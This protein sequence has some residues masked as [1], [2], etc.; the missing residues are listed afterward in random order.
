MKLTTLI[1]MAAMAAGSAE[2]KSD[3]ERQVKVYVQDNAGVP[4]IIL[5]DARREAGQIF[6]SIGVQLVWKQ[7]TP[8]AS[9]TDAIIIDLAAKT[10]DTQVPGALAYALPFEGVHIRIFWDRIARDPAS[11]A[12]L[13]HVMVHEI[14]H[15]LQ[16]V[17]R[18]SEEGIMKAHW[19][20]EDRLT[21]RR[22]PLSFTP[23]D[24]E[25]IFVGLDARASR[26]TNPAGRVDTIAAVTVGAE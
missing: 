23:K 9:E 15:I 21:M 4:F 2:A 25:L 19:T 3:H 18:H 8:S 6:H 22:T 1:L 24:V 17:A 7:G 10:P 11:Q 20:I 13:A 16:G 14:T 26:N 5:T 12:V